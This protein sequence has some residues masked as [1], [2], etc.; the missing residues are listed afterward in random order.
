VVEFP[1][2]VIMTST[3]C[4]SA[5]HYSSSMS[6]PGS[7]P[8]C[9]SSGSSTQRVDHVPT[10]LWAGVRSS[11]VLARGPGLQPSEGS[12]SGQNSRLVMLGTKRAIVSTTHKCIEEAL[13]LRQSAADKQS[14]Q[15]VATPQIPVCRVSDTSPS[16]PLN[17]S[18]C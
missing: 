16:G 3:P 18:I 7:Y 15:A 5:F 10:L 6:R 13:W 8:L 14:N 12:G 9:S 1:V 2:V 17:N 11:G 4:L